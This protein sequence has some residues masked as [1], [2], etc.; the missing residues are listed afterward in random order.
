MKSLVLDSSVITK[1][2]NDE[3]E[4][5]LEQ[6]DKILTNALE[7]Q[8]ELL[9]P[10]LAKYEIGNVLLKKGLNSQ[11]ALSSLGT[12]Y[13][14]PITF[15]TES[16]DLSEKTYSLANKFG[17]TYYDAAFLSIAERYKATLITENIKHQGKATNIQV[18]PLKD[19]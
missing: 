18:I 13:S 5:D 15:I 17:V 12:L 3:E 19:Y 4:K 6:A 10:E 1:W 2:L 14:L 16:N 8:V 11:Q 7:G 9:S